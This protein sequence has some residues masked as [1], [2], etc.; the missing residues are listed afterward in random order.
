MNKTPAHEVLHTLGLRHSFTAR[1]VDK[2]GKV[3]NQN[4]RYTYRPKY[5]NNIMDYTIKRN[6]LWNWQIKII[7]EHI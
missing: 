6:S 1:V 7:N 5:T 3:I 4:A 2:N